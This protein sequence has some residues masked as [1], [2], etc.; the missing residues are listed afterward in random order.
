[1]KILIPKLLTI[2]TNYSKYLTIK[3]KV[4]LKNIS[5]PHYCLILKTCLDI[6]SNFSKKNVKNLSKSQNQEL[7]IEH[8]MRH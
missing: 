8:S 1:M 6:Q 5:N 4:H 2:M 3:Q 7:L